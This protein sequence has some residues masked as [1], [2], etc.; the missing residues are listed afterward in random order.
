M[1]ATFLPER[2]ELTQMYMTTPIRYLPEN[3]SDCK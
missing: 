3:H 1:E 2:D